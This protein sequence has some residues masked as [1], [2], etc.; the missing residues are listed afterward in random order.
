MQFFSR[1]S[2]VFRN[3]SVKVRFLT[4]AMYLLATLLIRVVSC[5]IRL[6]NLSYHWRNRKRWEKESYFHVVDKTEYIFH[7][8]EWKR[9]KKKR[10]RFV[11]RCAQPDTDWISRLSKCTM[12]EGFFFFFFFHLK[13]FKRSRIQIVFR[14]PWFNQQNVYKRRSRK[15]LRITNFSRRWSLSL[16]RVQYVHFQFL[17]ILLLRYYYFSNR[18]NRFDHHRIGKIKYRWYNFILSN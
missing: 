16:H 6:I 18:S 13:N 15:T 17:K 3:V 9:R 5:S 11:S 10:A 4:F 12:Y 8:I 2:C 1:L 14:N 7:S